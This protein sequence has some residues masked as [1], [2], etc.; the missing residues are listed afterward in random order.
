[1]KISLTD[2]PLPEGKRYGI[3]TYNEGFGDTTTDEDY[4]YHDWTLNNEATKKNINGALESN[5]EPLN[6]IFQPFG[7]TVI[8]LEFY[9]PKYYNYDDDSIVMEFERDKKQIVKSKLLESKEL[10]EYF[11]K[12]RQPS[13][14]GFTSYE[15][16]G[17]DD[18]ELDDDSGYYGIVWAILRITDN[19]N[20]IVDM[21]EELIDNQYELFEYTPEPDE[22]KIKS[23]LKELTEDFDIILSN[24]EEYFNEITTR[25]DILPIVCELEEEQSIV[26]SVNKVCFKR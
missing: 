21:C 9:Q 17:I 20:L 3:S 7:I 2:L 13:S 1:M 8:G 6:K 11:E 19:E 26:D 15:P 24:P 18:I 5:I 12:H 10:K 14:D 16:I 22:D 4:E 25:E 23:R